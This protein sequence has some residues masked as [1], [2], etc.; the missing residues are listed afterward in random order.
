MLE[1]SGHHSAT[2]IALVSFI[3]SGSPVLSVLVS[4]FFPYLAPLFVFMCYAAQAKG[5]DDAA[6]NY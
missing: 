5:D 6:G 2:F 4:V 3:V 1:E